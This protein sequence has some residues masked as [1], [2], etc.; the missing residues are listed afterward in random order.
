MRTLREWLFD[1]VGTPGIHEFLHSAGRHG[2]PLRLELTGGHSI[3]RYHP[4]G[5]DPDRVVLQLVQAGG[6]GP[7]RTIL[8]TEIIGARCGAFAWAA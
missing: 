8:Y 2:D 3:E 6:F 1:L 4:V 7:T 5:I